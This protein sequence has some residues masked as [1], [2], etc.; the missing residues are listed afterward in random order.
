MLK[1]IPPILSPQLLSV[2]CAMGHGDEIVLADGNFPAESQ[3]VPVIRC[4]G[5]GVPVLLSAI[6]TLFPM[7]EYVSQPVALMDV[8]TGDTYKPVIWD[9][10][11]NILI[12][13]NC[14]DENIEYMERYAFYERSKKAFAIV[15]TSERSQYANIILKKGIVKA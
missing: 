4:D 8:I 3:N 9:E 13:H 14:K 7:D 10:Y 6:L 11:K 5:H 2:L 12:L 1:N 15:A